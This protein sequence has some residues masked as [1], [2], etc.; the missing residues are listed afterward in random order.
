MIFGA[1]RDKALDEM[2]AVLFPKAVTVILTEFDNPRAATI[3]S[4]KS[5][6]PESLNPSPVR[7]V[8]SIHQALEIARDLTREDGLICVTGS[9]YLVGQLRHHWSRHDWSGVQTNAD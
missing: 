6:I 2:S 4:L 8:S 7:G 1:M 3:D 9:L 5:S